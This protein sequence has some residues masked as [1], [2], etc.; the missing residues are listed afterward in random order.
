[1]RHYI[2]NKM[3]LLGAGAGLTLFAIFGLMPGSFLGGV[4][5]LN[6]AAAL[7]GSPVEPGIISR[8]VI[9]AGMLVGVMLS[10]LVFTA[11]GTTVGWLL[12]TLV[13]IVWKAK[14]PEAAEAHK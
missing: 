11:G 7:L 5:G 10:G 3:S 4:L 6:M 1:M 9:A 13:D 8:V 2:S 14:E 12:G